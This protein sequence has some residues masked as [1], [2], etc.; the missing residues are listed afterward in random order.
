MHIAKSF[1]LFLTFSSFFGAT[2]HSADI[3]TPDSCSVA[4]VVKGGGQ[5]IGENYKDSSGLSRSI[6]PWESAFG[7]AALSYECN[8]LGAQVDG[9]FYQHWANYSGSPSF[10]LNNGNGHIGGALFWRNAEMAAFG[11]GASRIFQNNS[12]SLPFG[13]G[14]FGGPTG[15]WR[16]G[17]FG[18]FYA[19]DSLTFG[20]G[21]YYVTGQTY[22][23]NAI[24]DQF[25][26]EGDL[27]AKFYAT[28]NIGLTLRGDAFSAS[29][30][31]PA[32]KFADWRGYALSAEAEYLFP[33]TTVSTFLGARLADRTRAALPGSGYYTLDETVAYAGVRF[34]FGGA[35][36]S[37]LRARDRHGPFD[38]T[39]VFEEKVPTHGAE[40][41]NFI[42]TP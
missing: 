22:L 13:G 20:A 29:W 36:Q 9:A 16:I 18:E 33:G 3:V 37:S 19:S 10:N 17:G 38:N 2:A 5:Y 21:A 4:G 26:F 15:K 8:G 7:E 32:V 39:S 41:S 28:D 11:I 34:D 31:F 23:A 6:T 14:P 30:Q 12:A 35:A 40:E 27:Y 42:L 25:G 1:G 24:F